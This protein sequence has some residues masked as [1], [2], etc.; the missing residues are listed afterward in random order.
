MHTLTVGTI[1]RT[2][3]G[4][5]PFP[6]GEITRGG[7]H[8]SANGMPLYKVAAYVPVL[9]FGFG[10][11]SELDFG[12]QLVCGRQVKTLECVLPEGFTLDGE[13]IELEK[14]RGSKSAP[15]P[16]FVSGRG[17]DPRYPPPVF[18]KAEIQQR[19]LGAVPPI[20]P[21]SGDS[22]LA[23]APSFHTGTGQR[24]GKIR[25]K[26]G[27]LSPLPLNRIFRLRKI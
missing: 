11:Q 8:F 9:L 18:L 10:D 17:S 25:R 12:T 1:S 26:C 27:E 24:S 4:I 23:H 6:P 20:F 5:R 15:A 22:D 16:S 7:F 14:P 2:S 3:L 21:K 13:M 19:P